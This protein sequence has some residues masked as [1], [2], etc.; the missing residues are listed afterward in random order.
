MRTRDSILYH[1][2]TFVDSKNVG[3]DYWKRA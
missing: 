1:Q 3:D 2:H